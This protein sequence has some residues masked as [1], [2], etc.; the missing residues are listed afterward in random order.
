M[1]DHQTYTIDLLKK[2]PIGLAHLAMG[3]FQSCQGGVNF[4]GLLGSRE[5]R[6]KK[7]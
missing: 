7:I 5:F 3:A 4:C 6:D 2:V 1:N